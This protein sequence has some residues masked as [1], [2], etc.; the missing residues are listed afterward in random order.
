MP[1]ATISANAQRAARFVL[2]HNQPDY[3]ASHEAL[4]APDA[5]VH[6]YLPGIPA[7]LDRT[8][9]AGFIANFR[10]ALPDVQNTIAEVIDGGDAVAIRWTGGGTHSGEPLMGLPAT[11]RP[12]VAHGVYILRFAPDGRI[13]EV[14]NHW[15][16]LNVLQQLGGA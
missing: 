13:G 8:G 16:N 2:E 5:L 14:W 6:E 10:S 4:L 11:G 15:D 3:L 7:A 1:T 12:V 9:Y